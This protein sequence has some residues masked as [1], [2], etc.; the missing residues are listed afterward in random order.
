M[1]DDNLDFE[2]AFFEKLL[3]K[4]PDFVEALTALGDAYTKKGLYEKGLE[5]DLRL[6]K[7][8]PADPIIHYNLACDYSLLKQPELCLRVLE[9]AI[10][11]GYRE[12]DYM[13][14]DPDLEYIRQ[15]TRFREL[16]AKYE[17]RNIPKIKKYE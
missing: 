11:L 1:A 5:T 3:D 13:E 17:E 2:I 14:K 8:R 9:T 10:K 15:D 4:N 12:F 6:V 16:I 7:F